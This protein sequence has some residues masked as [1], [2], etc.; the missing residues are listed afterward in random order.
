MIALDSRRSLGTFG[1]V[2]IDESHR[3]SFA[4][5]IPRG[6]NRDVAAMITQ[7]EEIPVQIRVQSSDW[8]QIIALLTIGAHWQRIHNVTALEH[9]FENP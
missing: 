8:R 7:I 6:R 1:F 2:G 5:Q 9:F 3:E 4:A